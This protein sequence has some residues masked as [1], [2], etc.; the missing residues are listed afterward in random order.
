MGL[1]FDSKY[2]GIFLPL[3]LSLFLVLSATYRK[4]LF[5][6]W[7][8]LAA[9]IFLLTISPVVI[10]NVQNNFASFRFQSTNHTSS[11]QG[12]TL[13]I[14]YF[15][16]VIGHQSAIL[17]PILF[18]GLVYFLFRAIKKNAFRI[19]T[20]QPT[21]TFLLSFFLPLFFFFFS[22]SFFFWVKL[23]WLMPVYITGII[24]VSRYFSDKWIRIQAIASLI[25]HSALALQIIFYLYPVKSDDTWYGW[26]DLAKQVEVV[27]LNY[28]DAFLLSADG[29]KTSAI[30][31]FYMKEKVYYPNVIGLKA[32]QMDFIPENLSVI[33]GKNAIFIDSSPQFKDEKKAETYPSELDT[34]FNAVEEIEP[35]LIK[36]NGV[37]VRKFFVYICDDYHPASQ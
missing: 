24:W 19:K 3:G 31:N 10:W 6:V 15:F 29:Y 30:L 4:Y 34:Y 36:R 8:W 37:T 22:I 7:Y 27:Q 17:I 33:N 23:N 2:T 35:I 25:I 26:K 20:I 21:T 12:L 9:L 28:P 11:A 14:K 5:S 1:A 32:L 16:G 13:N 18:F